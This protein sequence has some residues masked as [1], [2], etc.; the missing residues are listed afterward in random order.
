MAQNQKFVI[1]ITCGNP[2]CRN[3]NELVNMVS[4]VTMENM[5]LFY[6]S[7]D[8]SDTE[9]YCL[10]CGEL[11]VAEDPDDADLYPGL[12]AGHTQHS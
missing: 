11:G 7:Y 5:D 10:V 8:G 9:D 3:F 2:Q 12:N 6:E 1:P 4:G